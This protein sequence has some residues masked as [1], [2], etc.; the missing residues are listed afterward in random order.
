MT[1]NDMIKLALL[2]DKDREIIALER[3]LVELPES[4]AKIRRDFAART[5]AFEETKAH[6]KKLLI[7]RKELEGDL[8]ACEKLIGKHQAELNAVK[9]NEAFKAL[10]AEI[11]TAKNKKSEIETAILQCLDDIDAEAKKQEPL[12]Q[13]H[14][15]D[16]E[17]TKNTLELMTS[18]TGTHQNHIDALKTERD[19]FSRT[20]DPALADKDEKIRARRDGI[21]LAKALQKN[22]GTIFCSE[23]NIALMPYQTVALQKPDALIICDNCQRI[24]LPFVK[25]PASE[26]QD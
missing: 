22:S 12:A 18:E 4:T 24:I 15:L 23:C 26:T 8:A 17:R 11:A 14:K 10:L 5:A 19:L 7:T 25:E 13:E 9:S 2:Q 3:R 21:G 6:Y 1:P 20:I 16:E